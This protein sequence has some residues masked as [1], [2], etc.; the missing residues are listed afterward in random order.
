MSL[1]APCLFILS[2]RSLPLLCLNSYASVSK[3]CLF[4][5]VQYTMPVECVFTC[6]VKSRVQDFSGISINNGLTVNM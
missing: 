3:Y 4:T 6:A 5:S 1:N 2:N